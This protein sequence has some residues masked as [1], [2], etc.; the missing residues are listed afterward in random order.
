MQM[1]TNSAIVAAGNGGRVHFPAGTYLVPPNSCR[2]ATVA[3]I[4]G[5]LVN[6]SFQAH[7]SSAGKHRQGNTVLLKLHRDVSGVSIEG[8]TSSK[9]ATGILLGRSSASAGKPH[10]YQCMCR[11]ISR[12]GPVHR[13]QRGKHLRQLLHRADGI[14]CGWCLYVGRCFQW[15]RLD[16]LQHG[17]QHVHWRDHRQRV[18]TP[19][20]RQVSV[21][22][23]M[24]LLGTTSSSA[25]S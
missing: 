17:V 20:A 5:D 12:N 22:G 7:A 6:I 25:R 18:T 23:C 24:Q 8:D 3:T 1:F 13:G 15:W 16:W 9:P 14:H 19:Q 21:S 4:T 2:G 11:A 10:I